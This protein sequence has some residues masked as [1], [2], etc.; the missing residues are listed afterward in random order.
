MQT[1]PKEYAGPEY[2]ESDLLKALKVG[3]DIETAIHKF[4]GVKK[5]L[6]QE[7]FKSLYYALNMRYTENK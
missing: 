4:G 6:K 7:K 3:C 1:P 5:D 2:S